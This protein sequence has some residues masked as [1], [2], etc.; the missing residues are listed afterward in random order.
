MR[1]VQCASARK[2]LPFCG[3]FLSHV[4]QLA[5]VAGVF[6]LSVIALGSGR[7]E[8]QAW[9][10]VGDLN[11]ARQ[12]HAATVLLDGRVL[13]AGG[14][15]PTHPGLSS[16]EVYDPLTLTWTPTASMQRSRCHM[17]AVRLLDGRVLV[18][19]GRCGTGGGFSTNT[20]EIYD[21][22][23]D[24]WTPTPNMSRDRVGH[25]ATLLPDGRVLVAAG[26]SDSVGTWL[27]AAEIY[28]LRPTRGRSRGAWSPVAGRTRP[29]R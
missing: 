25:T 19:G 4:R 11:D 23:A 10:P 28:N 8:A 21:P 15:L 20:A 16:A 13:A 12:T 27:T 5:C 1:Y 3:F 2:P 26:Y 9:T 17:P 29:R 24:T 18:S 7:A 14:S 6:F 22:V